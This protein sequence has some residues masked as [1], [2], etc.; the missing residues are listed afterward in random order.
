MSLA[1]TVR[2]LLRSYTTGSGRVLLDRDAS[3]P[4]FALGSLVDGLAKTVDE[5][6]FGKGNLGAPRQPEDTVRV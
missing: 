2:R 5:L 6:A 4:K 1:A 3:L